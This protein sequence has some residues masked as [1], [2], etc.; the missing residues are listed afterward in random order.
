MAVSADHWEQLGGLDE[1][2]FAVNYND[3]DLC[4]RANAA[5]LR[6]IYLPHVQAI[7]HESKSRGRPKGAS[8]RQWRR[9]WALMESRWGEFLD[10][11]P[12][13]S[14]WLTLEDEQFGLSLRT[15]SLF[16]R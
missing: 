12:A 6:N 9:E 5:G 11:D 3:V 4:L 16:L 13:Y 14:P 2:G 1:Q 7:H 10:C 8:Y 15:Q